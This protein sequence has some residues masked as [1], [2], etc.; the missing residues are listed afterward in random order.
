MCWAWWG[1]SFYFVLDRKYLLRVN[2]VQKLELVQALGMCKGKKTCTEQIF[3]FYVGEVPYIELLKSSHLFPL[4]NIFR[5]N[6]LCWRQQKLKMLISQQEKVVWRRFSLPEHESCSIT[7]FKCAYKSQVFLNITLSIC[8]LPDITDRFFVF[9]S[10]LTLHFDL[11]HHVFPH[12]NQ[13]Y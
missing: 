5:S 3:G 1:R 2:L 7:T 6:N 9:M 10:T 11:S 12:I 13:H 8:N 4:G